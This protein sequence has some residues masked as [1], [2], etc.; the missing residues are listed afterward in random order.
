MALNQHQLIGWTAAHQ[1]SAMR[2]NNHEQTVDSFVWY[3]TEH[4]EVLHYAKELIKQADL[5]LRH[6]QQHPDGAA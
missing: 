1:F 3:L 5:M 6:H 4:P 2:D